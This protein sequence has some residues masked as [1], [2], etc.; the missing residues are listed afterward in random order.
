MVSAAKR[1]LVL[2]PS[3]AAVAN[4][5]LRLI[6]EKAQ[7]G[8]H[9]VVVWGDNAH[10]S[11]RFLNPKLRHK[12]YSHFTR[13]Y[14]AI[15]DELE[16]ERKLKNFTSWLAPG[17]GDLSL[18]DVESVCMDSSGHNSVAAASVV[19]CTLNTAGSRSLH[20]AVKACKNKFELCVLDEA[21]QCSEAEFY[22]ATSFIGVKR[23]V[24][25]GDPRQL[26][27]T[28]VDTKCEALGFGESFL[29]HL[30]KYNP[31]K[32]HL[33][34]VQYRMDPSS[35]FNFVNKT[36]YQNRLLSD[37]LTMQRSPQVKRPFL[38][39]SISQEGDGTE[40]REQFSYK[41]E[42]EVG[43]EFATHNSAL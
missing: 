22:M 9:N 3:N 1:A 39:I 32:V 24:V 43:G 35:L 27:P 7:Y 13:A 21:S 34:N 17:A 2:A 36:F 20:K 11:V 25:V 28:V 41:N 23:I 29:G 16:K 42:Y 10:H 18:K 40:E 15:E 31:G 33:L 4:V 6:N 8:R 38:F 5:A 19:L 30:L 12:E 26:G 37:Q 14:E